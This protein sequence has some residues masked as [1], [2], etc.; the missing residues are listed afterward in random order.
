MLKAQQ[1]PLI[2]YALRDAGWNALVKNLGLVNATRFILQYE[3]GYGEYVDMK[4][5]LFRGKSVSEVLKE[6]QQFERSV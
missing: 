1:K 6:V 4:K 5:A 3:P 2:G